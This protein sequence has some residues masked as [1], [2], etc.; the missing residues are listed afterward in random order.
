MVAQRRALVVVGGLLLLLTFHNFH[1]AEHEVLSSPP[2]PLAPPPPPPPTTPPPRPP[3]PHPPPPT[4]TTTPD[5]HPIP[6]ARGPFLFVAVH[7]DGS[8]ASTT[9]AL[10]P[11]R[12]TWLSR[13]SPQRRRPLAPTLAQYRFF[14]S[15]P[16]PSSAV[17]VVSIGE[18]DAFREAFSW[19]TRH[20]GL[21]HFYLTADLRSRN[22]QAQG[23]DELAFV[24]LDMIVEE[25][26]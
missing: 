24:C 22:G 25:L 18:G 7:A 21:P 2:P 13:L 17:D 3:P 8:D 20:V 19:A 9:T 5:G 26:R 11:Y 1:L 6:C 15:G 14:V 16:A 12:R 10:D 23:N 4:T